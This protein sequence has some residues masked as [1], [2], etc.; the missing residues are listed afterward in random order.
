MIVD[1]FALAECRLAYALAKFTSELLLFKGAIYTKP[2]NENCTFATSY[3]WRC[4]RRSPSAGRE[5]D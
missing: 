3:C 5:G 4:G 1:T 2:E